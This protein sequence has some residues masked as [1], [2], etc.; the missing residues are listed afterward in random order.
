MAT[1]AASF[2]L[3]HVAALLG[4]GVV[5]VSVARKVGLGA[6]LGYLLAGVAL[7]PFGLG[8]VKEPETIL[9]GI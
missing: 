6:V 4:A 7:G 2:G 5:A 9:R 1:E 8:L 3:G